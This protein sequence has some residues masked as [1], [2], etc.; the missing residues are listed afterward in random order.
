[1]RDALPQR[2]ATGGGADRLWFPMGKQ[3][4][5][6]PYSKHIGFSPSGWR[7]LP[8]FHW[9]KG[10]ENPLV[11]PIGAH[12]ASER[13]SEAEGTQERRV[14]LSSHPHCPHFGCFSPEPC[15]PPPHCWE[16]HNRFVVFERQ[17]KTTFRGHETIL[18]GTEALSPS[19][20]EQLMGPGGISDLSVYGMSFGGVGRGTP[21]G[22]P[23]QRSALLRTLFGTQHPL[24]WHSLS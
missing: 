2:C 11:S 7:H 17:R 4:L 10:G 14:K 3:L 1:M 12:H 18:H 13:R 20:R 6:S 15:L 24:R 19:A 22:A 8:C 23:Q 16:K 21:P 9:G 5:N